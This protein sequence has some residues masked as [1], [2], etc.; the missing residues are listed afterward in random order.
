MK[1]ITIVLL[2]LGLQTVFGQDVEAFKKSFDAVSHL[3]SPASVF[4]QIGVTEINI[5][6]YRPNSKNREIWGNVVTY[7][8]VWRAGANIATTIEFS[9]DVQINGNEIEQGKY[10]VFVIPNADEWTFIFDKKNFQFGSFFYQGETDALRV[11]VPSKKSNSKTESLIY[12]F[13]NVD[14]NKGELILAWSDRMAG[15]EIVTSKEAI[16]QSVQAKIEGAKANNNHQGFID[17]AAWAIDHQ[18]MTE[19]VKEWLSSSR[20]IKDTFGNNFLE[21]RYE[22]SKGNYDRAIKIAR[23]TGEKFPPFQSVLQSFITRWEKQKT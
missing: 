18:M 17:A 6:Y 23:K 8:K 14:Y 5:V 2:F 21:A 22:A 13:D 1:K 15:I 11:T 4:Q 9:R 20:K 7:G 16:L 12:Y 19:N 3:S 10:A